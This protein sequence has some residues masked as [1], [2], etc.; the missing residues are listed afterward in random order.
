MLV[1][2]SR[3]KRHLKYIAQYWLGYKNVA[4]EGIK[5]C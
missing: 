1:I 2:K 5:Q 3:C 4:Q